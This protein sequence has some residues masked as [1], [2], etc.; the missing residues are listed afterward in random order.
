LNP[1]LFRKADAVVFVSNATKEVYSDLESNKNFFT[2][3]NGIN[4][5]EID[6]FKKSHDRDKLK[7]E[8]GF[9]NDD[10]LITIVGTTC[11][12]KG[13]KVFVNAAIKILKEEENRNIQFLI[14]GARENTYEEKKY[15]EEIKEII[16]KNSL[17][18]NIPIIYSNNIPKR[19]DIFKYYFISDIFVCTSFVESLPIVILEAMAFELPIISTDVFGVKEEIEHENSGILIKP[20]D[21]EELANKIL[22]ILNDE[23]IAKKI[24]YNAYLRV[25]NCFYIK[26]MVDGYEEIIRK[27]AMKKLYGRCRERWMRDGLFNRTCMKRGPYRPMRDSQVAAF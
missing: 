5:K 10:K 27:M 24:G 17:K 20:G 3:Y 26:K 23:S 6:L 7:Q 1:S 12:R 15:L 4:T 2:V 11:H 25:K 22:Y 16:S 8:L 13:Q 18:F 9:L 14:V 19:E 21:Y